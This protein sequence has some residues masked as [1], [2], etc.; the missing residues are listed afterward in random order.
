MEILTSDITNCKL[1]S[2]R[3]SMHVIIVN[4]NQIKLIENIVNDL[5]RQN[6]IFDLTIFDNKST[7]I[8]TNTVYNKITKKWK[9]WVGAINIIKSKNNL[10]LT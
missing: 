4:N 2:S 6:S 1:K 8:E 3:A 5:I 7:E 10:S 9:S